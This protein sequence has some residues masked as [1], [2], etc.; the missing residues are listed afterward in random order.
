MHSTEV[1]CPF[2]KVLSRN[3]TIPTSE[4][5][6]HEQ[7]EKEAIFGAIRE[8]GG[9]DT[10]VLRSELGLIDD[11]REPV[12]SKEVS[13]NQ[14]VTDLCVWQVKANQVPDRNEARRVHRLL[15][16]SQSFSAWDGV[17]CTD[18]VVRVSKFEDL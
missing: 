1:S 16:R 6:H 14:N 5:K 9:D 4:S 8:P 17:C 15:L 2:G 13:F 10:L 11:E 3:G 7:E 12:N 18:G